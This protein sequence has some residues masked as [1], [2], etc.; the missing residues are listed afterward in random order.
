[1]TFPLAA[2]QGVAE[3]EHTED[4]EDEQSGT[5]HSATA[6]GDALPEPEPGEH[7]HEDE[8][9]V[10][11]GEPEQGGEQAGGQR[12]SAGELAGSLSPLQFGGAGGGGSFGGSGRSAHRDIGQSVPGTSQ[13]A[14]EIN[15]ASQASAASLVGKGRSNVGRSASDVA[16]QQF[17]SP[18]Q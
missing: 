17:G 13:R 7:A 16:R 15:A 10:Q 18:Q 6:F 8:H 5:A 3:D 11:Y 9:P 1:M 2:A 4:T 14:A 12:E